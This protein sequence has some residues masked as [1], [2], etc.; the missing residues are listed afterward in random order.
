MMSRRMLWRCSSAGKS[1]GE[2]TGT[3]DAIDATRSENS[4][5]DPQVDS[6]IL[7]RNECQA[8]KFNSPSVRRP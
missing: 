6:Q 8:Q 3:S 1:K 4:V 5:A 7:S 2:I